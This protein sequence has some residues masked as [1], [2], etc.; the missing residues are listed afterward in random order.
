MRV[1]EQARLTVQRRKE[2]QELE[3]F[4]GCDTGYFSFCYWLIGH[5]HKQMNSLS[6]VLSTS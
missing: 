6:P 2:G 4:S 3:P 1:R 5:I